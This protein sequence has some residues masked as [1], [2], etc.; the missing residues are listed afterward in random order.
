MLIG[1]SFLK[2]MYN[3]DRILGIEVLSVPGDA[4]GASILLFHG[5]GADALDLLTLSSLTEKK[6][7]PTWYFP[8]GPLEIPYSPTHVGH[9]WFPIDFEKLQSPEKIAEAFPAD[10]SKIRTLCTQ[11]IAELTIDPSK[12]FIG[13]FSQGAVLATEI[14]LHSFQKYAGLIIL[15]GTLCNEP[16]WKKL[17]HNHAGTPF[18]QSHGE[19]DPLLSLDLARRLEK[20]LLDGGLKGKLH[21]FQGGHGIPDSI[22]LKLKEFLEHSSYN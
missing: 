19:H 2:D 15:S 21:T 20:L 11:L 22:V 12:L 6:P 4:D 7:R 3:R 9:A 16:T 13:G 5:F 14:L 18:F 10:L 17:A 1:T 8:T